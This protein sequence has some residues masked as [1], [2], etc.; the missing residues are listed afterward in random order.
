M[1]CDEA[2]LKLNKLNFKFAFITIIAA[3]KV[4]IA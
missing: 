1:I 3:S 2:D 4:K